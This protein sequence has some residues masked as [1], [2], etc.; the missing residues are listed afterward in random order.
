MISIEGME[1][2]AFHGCTSDEKKVGIYFEV[3][4][5][6]VCDLSLPAISDNIK[7]AL[8]YQ[9]VYQLVSK[10][11]Q[12]TSNL[13][14]HVGQRIKHSILD[15]FPDAEEV[16]VKISKMNPPLGGKVK[17]VSIVV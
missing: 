8:N 5:H 4:V 6:I 3:D 16:S 13:L 2:Y 14:E 17:K 15:H 11:M 1:F 7:D 9:T 12:Q 10:E